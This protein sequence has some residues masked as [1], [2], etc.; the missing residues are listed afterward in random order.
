MVCHSAILLAVYLA[1]TTHREIAESGCN[2]VDTKGVQTYICRYLYSRIYG[3]SIFGDVFMNT[4][5][6]LNCL[7]SF[8]WN[9]LRSKGPI[10]I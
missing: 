5:I 7:D 4:Y 10:Y 8:V 2:M 6:V 9:S 3:V 1:N